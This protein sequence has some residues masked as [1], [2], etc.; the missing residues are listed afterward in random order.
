MNFLEY[1]FQTKSYSDPIFSIKIWLLFFIIIAVIIIRQVNKDNRKKISLMLP[2]ER[3]R[4][5]FDEKLKKD[6]QYLKIK[7][8]V[9]IALVFSILFFSFAPEDKVNS[10]VVFFKRFIN[11]P[12]QLCFDE[13]AENYKFKDLDSARILQVDYDL[14]NDVMFV[15]YKA[16]NG[17]G[18]YVEDKFHCPLLNGKYPIHIFDKME[19]LIKAEEKASECKKKSTNLTLLTIKN[20]DE[21]WVKR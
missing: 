8:K 15:T 18:A 17:F 16:K 7:K 9:A 11:D 1:F 13:K 3:E 12:G 6:A 4:F 10:V 14:E 5:L 21:Y 19:A 20:C 2:E